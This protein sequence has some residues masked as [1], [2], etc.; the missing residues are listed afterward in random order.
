MARLHIVTGKSGKLCANYDIVGLLFADADVSKRMELEQNTQKSEPPRKATLS[1]AADLAR[2]HR[3]R[4]RL[5]VP[6]APGGAIDPREPLVSMVAETSSGET[7]RIIDSLDL[8]GD[9]RLVTLAEGFLS[10]RVRAS[11]A[12]R[13]LALPEI[14][15][16]Q[17]KSVFEAQIG[18]AAF[19]AGLFDRKMPACPRSVLE[20]GAGV[21]IGIVDSGFDLSH[22]AFRTSSGTLRVDALWDQTTDSEFDTQDLEQKW[23]AGER[24][25]FDSR[26]HGTHVASIA[27]GTR[28]H[29]HEGIAPGARFLLVKTNWVDTPEAVAWIFSKARSTPCVVNLSLGCHNGAHDGTGEDERLHTKLVGAGRIVVVAAGNDRLRKVHFGH[30]FHEG[31]RE[32]AKFDIFRPAAGNP[33]ITLNAWSSPNDIFRMQ[34]RAPDG[35]PFDIPDSGQLGPFAHNLAEVYF[36]SHVDPPSGQKETRVEIGF[37]GQPE[38]PSFIGWRLFVECEKAAFGRFDAWISLS[39]QGAFSSHPMVEP[40]RTVCIP[41]TGRS[42]IAVGS[43]T[44]RS[45]WECDVNPI[46]RLDKQAV[47]YRFSRFSSLGPTRD[48]RWKPD[49]SAPGEH[50]CSAL[51]KDSDYEQ[52]S[53]RTQH[54]RR[55][56]TLQGTSMAAP[57]VS[58]VVA[59]LLQRKP[60]LAFEQVREILIKSARHDQYTGEGLWSPAYGH[61]KVHIQEALRLI[62]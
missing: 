5:K 23:R 31:E 15:F 58:G 1:L 59:L 22:P 24:P 12:Q 46:K 55:L 42:C 20:D 53:D 9:E 38:S 35:T 32:E 26:G 50:V 2:F 30:D 62:S 37:R 4:S 16:A 10:G 57:V 27:G 18:A 14:R 39:G 25:G 54:T 21:L 28:H 52:F 41:A 3:A 45:E 13:L 33:L 60:N 48:G 40:S 49:I 51:A 19:E 47:L 61:G 43:Y 36:A 11:T 44:S 7:S 34:L 29:D 6:L 56:V 8:A 17:S